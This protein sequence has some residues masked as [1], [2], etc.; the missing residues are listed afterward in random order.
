MVNFSFPKMFFCKNIIFQKTR[1]SQAQVHLLAL[2]H[3]LGKLSHQK[4]YI[5][6]INIVFYILLEIMGIVPFVDT[7]LKGRS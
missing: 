1:E 4:K 6:G 2:P 3:H 7:P 5:F